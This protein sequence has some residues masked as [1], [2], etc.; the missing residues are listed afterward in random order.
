[1]WHFLAIFDAENTIPRLRTMTSAAFPCRA[2]FVNRLRQA[3]DEPGAKPGQTFI[4][5]KSLPGMT[6]CR[7]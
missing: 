2:V 3:W 7:N 1:L 6:K 5:A 4:A